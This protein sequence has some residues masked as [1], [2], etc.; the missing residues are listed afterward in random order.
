MIERTRLCLNPCRCDVVEVTHERHSEY[1]YVD[2][3]PGDIGHTTRDLRNQRG[4]SQ[5]DLADRAGIARRT[6]QRI[7]AGDVRPHNDTVRR[8]AHA[9]GVDVEEMTSSFRGSARSRR[10]TVLLHLSPLSG[11][12]IPFAQILAPLSMWLIY[13]A[14]EDVL[15]SQ[16]RDVLLFHSASTALLAAGIMMIALSWSAGYLLAGF[17]I[18]TCTSVTLWNAYSVSERGTYRYFPKLAR[19]AGGDT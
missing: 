9:L 18:L 6:V 12:I 1:L 5:G 16:I 4:L 11:L 13:R 3:M 2:V 19:I 15:N 7:E 17:T 10:R 8:L 14:E